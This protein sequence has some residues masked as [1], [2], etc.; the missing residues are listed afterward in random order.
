MKCP[1]CQEE[2]GL[3]DICI[4]PACSYFGNII[5][6]SKKSNLN[7][8]NDNLD[9]KNSY[10][11]KSNSYN[12][13]ANINLNNNYTNANHHS[14]NSYPN[15]EIINKNVNKSFNIYN[16]I[17]NNISRE[18]FAAFIGSHNTNYYLDRINKIKNNNRFPSWNWPC[19]FLGCYW[20][21]YR[22][23]YALASLLII[24]NFASSRLLGSKIHIFFMLIIHIALTIFS[25]SIYINNAKRKIK[26]VKVNIANLNTTQYINRLREEGGVN[27]VAP[28]IL[29]VICVF[30][31]IISVILS[32][33]FAATVNPTDFS[34]PSYH[35]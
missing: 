8:T 4:N 11:N 30:V 24:L 18:E 12:S 22:K 6:S 31:G 2:L 1:H 16:T 27:L 20:L 25:N 33:L 28:L 23:L 5:E 35:Y 21:L 3:N 17:D 26:L 19:F 29:V 34:A 9:S 15:K 7:D 32:L 13:K 10:N 14:I